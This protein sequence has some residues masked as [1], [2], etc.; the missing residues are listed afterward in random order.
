MQFQPLVVVVAVSRNSQEVVW[1]KTCVLRMYQTSLQRRIYIYNKSDKR[2]TSL[3]D[4]SLL[5]HVMIPQTIKR[6]YQINMFFF[7]F[8][9]RIHPLGV[10]HF[11]FCLKPKRSKKDLVVREQCS[12]RFARFEGGQRMVKLSKDIVCTDIPT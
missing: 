11:S 9:F 12:L 5:P 6:Q 10:N 8:L 3:P 7:S 2:F 4:Q 1:S